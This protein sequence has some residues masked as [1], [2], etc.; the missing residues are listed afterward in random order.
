MRNPV[1]DDDV[2]RTI[3]L[4]QRSN[5]SS[6]SR[7]AASS[8]DYVF[9]CVAWGESGLPWA[10][11]FQ[12]ASKLFLHN[13]NW[14]LLVLLENEYNKVW[15]TSIKY[16]IFKRYI[17][18]IFDILECCICH[19]VPY[20]WGPLC[21]S[22]GYIVTGCVKDT[23]KCETWIR[24]MRKSRFIIITYLWLSIKFSSIIVPSTICWWVFPFFCR[25]MFV[26]R[27]LSYFFY[28]SHSSIYKKGKQNLCWKTK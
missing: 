28:S 25:G 20:W 5:L 15:L 24:I 13:L 7:Q 14:M 16:S 2:I 19:T 12:T 8:E 22:I 11:F 21:H 17:I 9:F 18:V 1:R 26:S 3:T 6:R 27:T 23:L 10:A 4:L